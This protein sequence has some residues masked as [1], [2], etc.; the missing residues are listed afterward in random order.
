MAQVEMKNRAYNP[1]SRCWAFVYTSGSTET[2]RTIQVHKVHE[3]ALLKVNIYHLQALKSFVWL[4]RVSPPECRV[5]W[6]R[7][8][9]LCQYSQLESSLNP[10][11]QA[12][13]FPRWVLAGAAASCSAAG[14]LQSL[15]RRWLCLPA[16]IKGE[17]T[18]I[19]KVLEGWL[20]PCQHSNAP[21]SQGIWDNGA[22][23]LY[24][25]V[26]TAQHLF[27]DRDERDGCL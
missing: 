9:L 14:E 1:S 4:G 5:K 13:G 19:H 22:C 10:L 12:T 16:G 18:G 24:A 26:E 23:N 3:W 27:C 7:K 8:G 11:D 21:H 25:C 15:G 2:S 6:H 20:R 17:E